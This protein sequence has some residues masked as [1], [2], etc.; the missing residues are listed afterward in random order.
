MLDDRAGRE[1]PERAVARR[2]VPRPARARALLAVDRGAHRQHVR[3][4]AHDELVLQVVETVQI[5]EDQAELAHQLRV[6]EVLPEL[7]V[8]FGHEQRVVRGSVAIKAAS[9]VKLFSAGWHVPQVRPLPP[10]VSLKKISRPFATWS[11]GAGGG[12]LQAERTDRPA[13]SAQI[14]GADA[15]LPLPGLRS[16]AAIRA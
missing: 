5:L 9:S 10:N 12:V 1:R 7:G 4:A 3:H 14:T 11:T 13:A 15:T 2:A 8:G 16:C 6:L